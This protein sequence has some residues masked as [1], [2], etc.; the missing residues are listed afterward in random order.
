M[1][2]TREEV[3]EIERHCAENNIC[4]THYLKEKGI[5]YRCYYRSKQQFRE[6]DGGDRSK[7]IGSFIELPSKPGTVVSAIMPPKKTHKE[8]TKRQAKSLEGSLTIEMQ[9]RGGVAMRI[10]GNFSPSHLRELMII[11]KESNV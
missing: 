1:L 5:N 11:M 2:L 8:I 4:K 7:A 6:E 3:L 10:Q 9:T